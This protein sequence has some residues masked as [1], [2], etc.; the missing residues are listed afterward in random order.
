MP[1]DWRTAYL[2]QARSDYEM[3]QKLLK[4]GDVPTCQR[5]H[6]L[7]MTTEKLAKGFLT[8]PSGERPPK[9]HDAFLKFVTKTAQLNPSLQRACHFKNSQSEGYK[10]YL[11]GL[12]EIA[13]KI[14]DL[15]PEGGD[16]PNPEY[17]WEQDG[18]ILLPLTYPYA[19]LDLRQQSAK[20]DKMLKFI[21]ACFRIA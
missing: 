15:S 4:D 9:I 21:E 12:R 19:D 2:K 11:N 7:Q 6:Y 8:Q 16:H 13:K 17:P 1:M 14:E 5:L 20:M 3:L 10:N 18:N